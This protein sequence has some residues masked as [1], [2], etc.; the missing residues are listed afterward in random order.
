VRH[1]RLA[2]ALGVWALVGPPQLAGAEST[3]PPVAG[4]WIRTEHV[5]DD[6]QRAA[7][8]ERITAPLPF[9][10]RGIARMLLESSTRAPEV[11]VVRLVEAGVSVRTDDSESTVMRVRNAEDVSE[12]AIVGI[13]FTETGFVEH[14]QHGSESRGT[15]RWMLSSDATRLT[16]I[17]TVLDDRFDGEF[18]YEANYRRRGG[19]EPVAASGGDAGS[20]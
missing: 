16:V 20:R 7:E 6:D 10:F 13:D 5:A 12:G 15:T 4:E 14:W 3:L 17:T 11:Y 8:L 19:G 2:L 18:A 9:V 1:G